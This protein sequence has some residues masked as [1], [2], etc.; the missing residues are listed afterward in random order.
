LHIYNTVTIA[1][2]LIQEEQQTQQTQT[3]QPQSTV[4][5]YAYE[6]FMI[7]ENK[8]VSG[9]APLVWL[10][11][12]LVQPPNTTGG[13][14]EPTGTAYTKIYQKINVD[15][16]SASASVIAD[17]CVSI[18]VS[19][20]TLFVRILPTSQEKMQL[21]GSASVHKAVARD[22]DQML[23]TLPS[24]VAKFNRSGTDTSGTAA[25]TTK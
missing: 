22:I 5:C 12:K 23:S 21:Q 13:P 7:A 8:R 9:A 18:E 25:T 6:T 15:D 24:A 4:P 19:F 2:R 1:F 20:P 10:Y 11:E 16:V 17:S 3:Q 14:V